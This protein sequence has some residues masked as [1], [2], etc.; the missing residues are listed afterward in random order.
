M[1]LLT[2]LAVLTIVG[3]KSETPDVPTL[4]GCPLVSDTVTEIALKLKTEDSK[5]RD[6][7]YLVDW[8]DG[9][10]TGW[11]RYLQSGIETEQY[12]IY[13]KTGKMNIRVR[14]R[15]Q[16]FS[17]SDTVPTDWS[18]P[19]SVKVVPNLAIWKFPLP[20]GTFCSAALDTAGN[21]YFGDEAGWFYSV[22][23]QGKL[24]WQFRVDDTLEGMVSAGAA[25]G[26][27]AVYFPC[28]DKHLYCLSLAGKRLWSYR[29]ASPVVAAPALAADGMVYCADDS[30]IVY[31]LNGQG[32][33]KWTFTTNDE[34]DNGPTIGPDGTIYV[35]SDSLYA[36][37]PGGKRLW[38]QGAQE[39]DNP[40][41]GASI[42]PDNE[43]YASNKDGY[44]YHLD[45][46]SGRI[47][48]RAPSGD[49]EEMHG[50]PVFGPDN[51]IYFGSDDYYLNAVSKD[52]SSL[53]QLIETDDQIRATPAVNS[54]GTIYFLSKDGFMYALLPDG[55]LK[56]K[57]QI[58]TGDYDWTPSSPVIGPDGTV[59]VGSY[60]EGFY[61]FSGDGAPLAGKWSMLRGNAQH[62]GRAVKTK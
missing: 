46:K 17:L 53:R 39:E 6:V 7:A 26:N 25:V 8:G 18:R 49:E 23:P 44:L 50:E 12:H 48:W 60:D 4:V 43:V 45:P 59:Y 41:Y 28:E 40:F 32:I 62:T 16:T 58:G 13:N 15:A 27:N 54:K 2:V 34:V 61:A 51:T 56:W 33:L 22:T 57:R 19:C 10:A 20:S 38:A 5:K 37:T 42:G 55:K 31:C 3:V 30:G 21:V 47:L 29:T 24:R 35:P 36:L 52:G 14:A 1:H 11:S 9:S